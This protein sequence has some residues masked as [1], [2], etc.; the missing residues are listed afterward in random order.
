MEPKAIDLRRHVL[1]YFYV[2]RKASKVIIY[3]QPLKQLFLRA[4]GLDYLDRP[5]VSTVAH[6]AFNAPR[7][8]CVYQSLIQSA[9]LTLNHTNLI[10]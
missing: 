6:W 4:K 9:E 3:T 1:R 2:P 10:N 5:P 7:N 8:V